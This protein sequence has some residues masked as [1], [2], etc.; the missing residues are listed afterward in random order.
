MVAV[1]STV[2][3]RVRARSSQ[4]GDSSVAVSLLVSPRR[5]SREG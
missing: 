3:V 2:W 4:R 1:V 5:A